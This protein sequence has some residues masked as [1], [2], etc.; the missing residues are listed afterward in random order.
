VGGARWRF[1]E[2]IC[3][4][5]LEKLVENGEAEQAARRH[6]V[7]FRDLFAP[8]GQL[9]TLGDLPRY[10]QE[11]GNVR[12]AL[13]WA[14]SPSGD[15]ALGVALTAAYAPVWLHLSL[16]AECRDRVEHAR[17]NLA[18]DCGLGLA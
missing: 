16:I 6:G 14:F 3:A 7:F 18:E 12:A 4:Y 8:D 17:N 1:L 11:M 10:V 5:A 2:T 9:V 13:D 15:K